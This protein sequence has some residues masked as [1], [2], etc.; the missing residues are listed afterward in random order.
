MRWHYNL[1]R[2]YDNSLGYHQYN[3]YKK[4]ETVTKREILFSIIIISIMLIIG[5]LLSDKINNNLN[6]DYQKYNTAMQIDNDSKLFKH[7]MNTS[8]GNA[9]IYGDLKAVDAVTF[10]EIGG[11]YIYVKKVKEKYTMHSRTVRRGKII[12]VEYYW[13]WDAVDSEDKHCKKISFLNVVFD[14]GKIPLPS[15]TYINTIQE[16]QN[17][18]YKYYGCDVKYYGTLYAVLKDNTITDASFYNNQ[19]IDETIKNLESGDELITFW[20]FWIIVM[21]IVVVIFYDAENKWLED[22]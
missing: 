19:K 10:K 13:T 4:F 2:N 14:Y 15:K 9:F 16:S 18:R 22:N 8:I 12:R 3:K 11:K 1:Y 17:T 6:E 21:I 20:I 7:C 5:F